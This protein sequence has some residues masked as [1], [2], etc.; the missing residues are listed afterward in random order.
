MPNET[1]ICDTPESINAFVVLACRGALNLEKLGMKRRGTSARKQA[2][3]ILNNNGENLSYS[4]RID[5]VIAKFNAYID[6]N[7]LPPK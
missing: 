4:T 7:I 5:T 2:I 6:A 1:I 3:A